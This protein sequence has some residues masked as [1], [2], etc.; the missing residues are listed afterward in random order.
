MSASALLLLHDAR[1]HPV[2]E[3]HLAVV[4][5]DLRSGCWWRA[6]PSVAASR[7]AP[8]RAWSTSPIAPRSTQAAQRSPPRRSRRSCELVPCRI[9][10][11]RNSSGTGP[12]AR[13]TIVPDAQDLGV[14]A[15]VPR[16]QRVL[17]AQRGADRER[18][19]R[20]R[21]ARTGAPASASTTLTPTVRSS[22]LLP[23]MFEPLTTITCG[24]PPPSRT[25]LR[26]ARSPRASSGCASASASNSGPV[27]GIARETD[28]P[29]C[30]YA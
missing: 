4:A 14:E 26:H 7:S 19:Q 22:V 20:S 10:S 23:D 29:G 18:R 8:G 13:S 30:S 17:D 1:S 16:L 27:V 2:V 21:R 25:S 15:R 28:P 12:R 6:T 11:S 24:A 9:S 3:R 5:A